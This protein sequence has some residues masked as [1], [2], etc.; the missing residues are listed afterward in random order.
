MFYFYIPNLVSNSKTIQLPSKPK[1]SE[2]YFLVRCNGYCS[3]VNISL[4]VSSGDPDLFAL[5][6]VRPQL[7][8][9]SCL[10]CYPFC[11]SASFS[12]TESCNNITTFTEHLH[13]LVHAY[14]NYQNGTITFENVKDVEEVNEGK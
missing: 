3:G 5:D 8:K 2:T 11:F 7:I 6:Y 4:K 14:E 12:A 10:E 9:Y 13:V 1:G